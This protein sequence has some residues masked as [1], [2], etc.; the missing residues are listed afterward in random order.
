MQVNHAATSIISRGTIQ[1]RN[2]LHPNK[3][4]LD[5]TFLSET[6]SRRMFKAVIGTL[7]VAMR[8]IVLERVLLMFQKR[9]KLES[10]TLISATLPAEEYW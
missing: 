2:I 8:S 1:S 4:P 7:H 3:N 6:V 10:S 5:L 9:E